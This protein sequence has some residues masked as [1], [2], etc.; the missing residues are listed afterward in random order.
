MIG[1]QQRG[2]GQGAEMDKLCNM[3]E[4]GAECVWATFARHLKSGT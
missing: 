4:T 3:V 1:W 2:G